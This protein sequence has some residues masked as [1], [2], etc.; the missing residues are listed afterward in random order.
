MPYRYPPEFR[1]KALDLLAAGTSVASLSADLGVS[2]QTIY[3]RRRQDAV[4]RGLQPGLTSSEKE[5]LKAARR[6]IA[7]LETEQAVTKLANEL[8]NT[9]TPLYL[10]G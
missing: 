3:N 6:R 2:D 1:R 8:L 4:D 9:T 5:E 10:V 7:E